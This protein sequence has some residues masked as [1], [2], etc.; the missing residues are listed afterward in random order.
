[1]ATC[2]RSN[3]K[4]LVSYSLYG[5]VTFSYSWKGDQHFVR[6]KWIW[7]SWKPWLNYVSFHPTSKLYVVLLNVRIKKEYHAKYI[8]IIQWRIKPGKKGSVA[9]GQ[10]L[11]SLFSMKPHFLIGLQTDRWILRCCQSIISAKFCRYTAYGQY[12]LIKAAALL[13]CRRVRKP[14]FLLR[15]WINANYLYCCLWR[16]T[17][18]LHHV[19]RST[20]RCAT[21]PVNQSM[22]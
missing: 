3:W 21:A 12:L 15:L 16:K 18:R 17:L 8:H 11:I 6:L 13:F 22:T 4:Y 20:E 10:L 7:L 19:V 2:H 9:E 1:L 5:L 14:N